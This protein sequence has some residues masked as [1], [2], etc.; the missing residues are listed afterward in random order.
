MKKNTKNPI[1]S[2]FHQTQKK[3]TPG[4]KENGK[5]LVHYT[6]SNPYRV[7]FST[8][9]Y[10]STCIS[11]YTPIHHHH[12]FKFHSPWNLLHKN[13]HLPGWEI[14]MKHNFQ[15]PRG[16][17][18]KKKKYTI[19][20]KRIYLASSCN[21]NNWFLIGLIKSF[22]NAYWNYWSLYT[23]GNFGILKKFCF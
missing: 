4:K 10:Y 15:Q 13:Y 16:S 17:V 1:S 18:K 19:I 22:W 8:L 21:L 5:G 2:Q 9:Y 14:H 11:K 23:S 7:G 6:S 12:P 3:K 20:Q